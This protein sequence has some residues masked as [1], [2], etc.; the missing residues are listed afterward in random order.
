M[1]TL[2]LS[3]TTSTFDLFAKPNQVIIVEFDHVIADLNE[4]KQPICTF[5]TCQEGIELNQKGGKL[6]F[7]CRHID[8]VLSTQ[9][10]V[11][12][13]TISPEVIR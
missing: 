10:S 7:R 11:P 13:K 4:G 5:K 2:S 3:T 6:P 8:L 1:K 12:E 9:A